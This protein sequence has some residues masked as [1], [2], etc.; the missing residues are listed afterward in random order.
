MMVELCANNYAIHDGL[1]NGINGVFLYVS[2][3]HDSESLIWIFLIIQKLVLQP[4][5]KINSC[6]QPIFEEIQVGGN[7][8]QVITCT[9]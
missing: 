2:K 7:S 9:Q 5:Y 4:R 1:F 8:S 3:S 6:T